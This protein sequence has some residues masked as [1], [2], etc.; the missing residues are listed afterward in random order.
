MRIAESKPPSFRKSDELI[1]KWSEPDAEIETP[2][3][4]LRIP[5]L[6][7]G[8]Q[9]IKTDIARETLPNVFDA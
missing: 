3:S 4:A 9:E 1:Y 7:Y 5:N 6:N 2:H 8:N